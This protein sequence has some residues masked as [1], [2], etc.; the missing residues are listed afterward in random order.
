MQDFFRLGVE[1]WVRRFAAN[2]HVTTFL[3]AIWW[4]WRVRNNRVLG[5]KDWT[6]G[7]IVRSIHLIAEDIIHAFGRMNFEQ[8]NPKQ[9]SWQKPP[10]GVFKLN[11]DGSSM[12]N[13]GKAGFGS[14]IRN[15]EGEWI[16]GWWGRL[17][18]R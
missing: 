10:Q 8:R 5:D 2:D 17:G 1:D 16:R 6:D 15:V 9:I 18:M 12:A 3:S 11:I 14:V 4:I 7:Q 13:L